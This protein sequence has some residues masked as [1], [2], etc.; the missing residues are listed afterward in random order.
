MAEKRRI[1]K[2]ISPGARVGAA[3]PDGFKYCPF[4]PAA[5]AALRLLRTDDP[6]L[7][8]LFHLITL[9]GYVAFVVT[10]EST[11]SVD[12]LPQVL[13]AVT[14]FHVPELQ[15]PTVPVVVDLLNIGLSNITVDLFSQLCDPLADFFKH[16]KA[17]DSES[18]WA[19]CYFF[20]PYLA[21]LISLV[22][23]TAD[24]IAARFSFFMSMLLAENKCFFLQKTMDM[25]YD[26]LQPFMCQ[27]NGVALSALVSMKPSLSTDTIKAFYYEVA[28][29]FQSLV[30]MDGPLLEAPHPGTFQSF[31]PIA[32]LPNRFQ[33]AA[34]ES[35]AS[36]F[37]LAQKV[38][39]P[40]AS[41]FELCSHR[42]MTVADVLARAVKGLAKLLTRG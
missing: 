13:G 30:E 29:L 1:R 23:L 16:Q 42:V 7:L 11:G 2:Q 17:S 40:E 38:M 35:F 25:F 26:L 32:A 6:V 15:S 24:S 8:H 12:G 10:Y 4:D 37:H 31:Q 27:L 19:A 5:V 21:K 20:S 39:F 28:V 22:G 3:F 34:V 18:I 9:Y 33:F 41:R 14:A 36:G